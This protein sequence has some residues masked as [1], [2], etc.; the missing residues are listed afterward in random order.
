MNKSGK[1]VAERLDQEDILA[2]YRQHFVIADPDQIYLDGNSLGRLSLVAQE[3][4]QKV[5]QVEWGE[6]L[7]QSWNDSWMEASTRIGDKIALLIG[8]APGE[9][10]LADTTSVNL[11]KLAAGALLDQPDRN[12]I[13][14]DDLNF[15]SD[16]YILDGVCKL[17]GNRHLEI[18][19]S[20]DGIHGPVEKIISTL[21]HHTALLTLSHTTFKSGYF[22][23]MQRLTEAAQ[24]YGAF[25][26]WDLSHSVGVIPLLLNDSR[27]DLAVGCTYKYLNGGPGSPAFIYVRQDLQDRL[28]NPISGWMGHDNI[29]AF[30]QEYRPATDIR[31]FLSGTPPVLALSALEASLEILLEAGIDRIREKSV[32][33]TNYLVELWQVMLRS[34][35]YHLNSPTDAQWRGSHV[36]LGHEEALRIDMALI[37]EM[38][39]IP[40]FREPDNLRLGFAPLYTSFQDIYEA[41]TRMQRVVKDGLYKKYKPIAGLV[42]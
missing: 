37:A 34:Y 15:P 9:V 19:S 18:V 31:R 1:E 25:V 2:H 32:R 7:I 13:V 4:L 6:R 33:L 27:V 29:F 22:Y 39:V 40:D 42:T 36:S 24:R 5:I 17:L 41:V 10:V 11:F 20:D 12:K 30:H 3:R 38:N 35:G 16:L 26:L 14:T 23:D 8:A 28:S 21:D